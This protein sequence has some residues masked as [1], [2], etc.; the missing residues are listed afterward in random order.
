MSSTGA[1]IGE[2]EANVGANYAQGAAYFYDAPAD[3]IFGN[4]FE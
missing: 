2:P 3:R 1:V 4:G